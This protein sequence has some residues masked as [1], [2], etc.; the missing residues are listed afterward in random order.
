MS[1]LNKSEKRKVKVV[2]S[3]VFKIS[4]SL[5]KKMPEL[6]LSGRK[7]LLFIKSN[8]VV[9]NTREKSNFL[10]TVQIKRM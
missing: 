9:G 1:N 4:S 6:T 3:C 5:G 7:W 2:K 8:V 10:K